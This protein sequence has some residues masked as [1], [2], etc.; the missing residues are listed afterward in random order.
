VDA[1]VKKEKEEIES[2]MQPKDLEAKKAAEKADK[3]EADTK[4]K[5]PTLKRKGEVDTPKK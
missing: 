1:K 5:A 3:K 4:R 2:V